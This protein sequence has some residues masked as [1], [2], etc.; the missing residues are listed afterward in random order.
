M[1]YIF[2]YPSVYLQQRKREIFR[3]IIGDD[4]INA[5]FYIFFSNFKNIKKKISF[6][7]QKFSM[8]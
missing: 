5:N 7:L 1:Y 8:N 4:E 3:V 6:L 2:L